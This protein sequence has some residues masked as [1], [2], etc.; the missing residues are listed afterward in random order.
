MKHIIADTG[1]PACAPFAR[2]LPGNRPRP[3]PVFAALL[4]AAMLLAACGDG[5]EEEEAAQVPEGLVLNKQKFPNPAGVRCRDLKGVTYFATRPGGA[6]YGVCLFPSG[7]QCEEWTML[8][9]FCPV[10]GV[11]VSVYPTP[12]A[13]YC[14]L[15]GGTYTAADS[16]GGQCRTLGGETC[17]AEAYFA[18]DC[19]KR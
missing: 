17:P 6:E 8:R 4:A 5:K 13:R 10:G 19:G 7:G 1:T 14:V 2:A 3:W 9:G 11:D 16:G 12:A 18:G 15:R